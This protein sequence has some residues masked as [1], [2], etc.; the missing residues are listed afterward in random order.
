M[1]TIWVHGRAYLGF[2]VYGPT[3]RGLDLTEVGMWRFRVW[4]AA[5]LG[6]GDGSIKGCLGCKGIVAG[7]G[8]QVCLLGT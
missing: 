7:G 2:R 5:R 3:V 1:Y 4:E 6:L 8:V